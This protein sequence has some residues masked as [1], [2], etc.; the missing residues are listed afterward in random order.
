MSKINEK[1]NYIF[2]LYTEEIPASYQMAAIKQLEKKVPQELLKNQ[3]VCDKIQAGGS[4][5]RLF[6][7]IENLS[8][9]QN[10]TEEEVKGPPKNVCYDKNNK[11]TAALEG[12]AKKVNLPLEK[13]KFQ[14]IGKAEYACAK[15]KQGGKH[16]EEVFP[17]LFEK[18]I[19]SIDFPKVM[20]WNDLDIE[21]PRPIIQ[22]LSIYGDKPMK[23]ST[24]IWSQ[25]EQGK[26]VLGH[27]ILDEKPIEL[28]DPCDYFAV[29]KEKGIIVD[30]TKRKEA[31]NKML[32]EEASKNSLS[33]I[34]DNSL[35]E[36]V[37][38]IVERPEV[39]CAEFPEDFLHLPDI[40]ALSEMQKHQKYFGMRDKN[41]KLS[42][43]FLIVTNA[44]LKSKTSNFNIK[45]GNERVLKARLSDGDFFY[46]EDRKITL[47]KRI[48]KLKNIVFQETL[49]SMFDKKE[50]IK[51]IASFF[52]QTSSL[53][54]SIEKN[55][56][57]RASD[58]LK[59]DLT[60]QLVYEFDH[61]QGEIGKIYAKLDSEDIE[62]SEAIFEHYL[63][64]FQD[65]IYPKTKLGILLSLCE[66][67]DNIYA[68]FILGKNPTA[69]QDPFGLRRQ[70]IYA[71]DI[72]IQNK[73]QFDFISFI[74]NFKNLYLIKNINKEID[75]QIWEFFK[76]RIGGIFEKQGFNKKLIAAGLKTNSKDIYD[77]YCKLSAMKDIESDKEFENLMTAFKRMN[78]IVED[79]LKK[80][81]FQKEKA[82]IQEN[83]FEKDE[84]KKLYETGKQLSKEIKSENMRTEDYEKFFLMLAKSKQNVDLFFDNVMVMVD[85]KKIQ[86][87]RLVLLYSVLQ[88][89]KSILDLE[90]LQ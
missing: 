37:T 27:F 75:E 6:V 35:L 55:K 13:I 7:Y 33:A 64:R 40:V 34:I 50:R 59:T 52:T 11:P 3:I 5:R 8:S 85:D 78:N 39:V 65:D 12:F 22:Y 58:L 2:E 82:V 54:E 73:I 28:K 57:D 48:E 60:T 31:I 72:I 25:I 74:K 41:K 90:S 19:F 26:N 56:I 24:E 68:G 67:F 86:Q 69:S 79:A 42:S 66:K 70:A 80:K 15:I 46:K 18:L 44:S 51:Q 43:K 14:N 38:F 20:K 81:I 61:L 53:F 89:V 4:P 87:N 76:G 83:L 63:P 71:I 88:P 84:E 47:E 17:E 21:Y 23:F 32:E 36:E 10:E 1:K 9:L 62:V 30:H 29:L 45:S 77:L 16:I 49:G